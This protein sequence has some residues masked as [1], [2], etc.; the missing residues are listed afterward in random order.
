MFCG[1]SD[2][3]LKFMIDTL[4]DREKLGQKSSGT[5]KLAR[6]RI[7]GTLVEPIYGDSPPGD[8]C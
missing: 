1:S 2:E 4:C 5:G 8:R 6:Q 7:A 3:L